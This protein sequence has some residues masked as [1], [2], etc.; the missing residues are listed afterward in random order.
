MKNIK[1]SIVVPIYNIEKY[2]DRCIISLI[3]QTLKEIEI[4]LVDDCSKD[5]SYEICKKYTEIDNRI[6]LLKN[7]INLGVGNTRNK[8]IDIAK[9]EYISFVDADDWVSLDFYEKLYY[10]AKYRDYDIAKGVRVEINNG[11]EVKILD[12]NNTI[13]EG[14]KKNIPLYILFN[15]EH[16]SA[17]YKREFLNRNNLR[18]PQLSNGQDMLFL[19]YVCINT[20]KIVINNNVFYYYFLRNNSTTTKSDKLYNYYENILYIDKKKIEYVNN[21]EI[22]KKNYDIFYINTVNHLIKN[23]E[24]IKKQKNLK[25]YYK[26]Y[27]NEMI[28]IIFNNYKYQ[29]EILNNLLGFKNKKSIV[30][31][32]LFELIKAIIKKIL[33]K[34][35]KR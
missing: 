24:D 32:S 18:Y 3:N 6:I 4:I 11:E 30:D 10:S 35:F 20:N 13:I 14:I 8:G 5:N 16:W 15:Y 1:V 19:F 23:Y 34:I 17:I 27:Y 28:S 25:D 29:D 26:D 9:G 33:F 12:L 22:S 2:L 21:I 31:Y 7:E